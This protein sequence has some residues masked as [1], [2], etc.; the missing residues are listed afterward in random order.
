MVTKNS[1]GNYT[2]IRQNRIWTKNGKKRQRRSLHNDKGVNPSRY[3]NVYTQP[4]NT[5]IYKVKVN[6]AKRRNKQ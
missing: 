3:K 1:K 6:R 2:Y 5:Q 4:G